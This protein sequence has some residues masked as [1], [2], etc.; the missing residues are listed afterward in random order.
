[1]ALTLT[2]ENFFW[3]K[4]H[5][6]TGVVPV[7]YYMV[8]HLV[9]NSFSLGGPDYFNGVIA[10]FYGMPR[11]I[12]LATEIVLIWIPLLFH[13]LYGFVITSHAKANYFSAKYRWSENRMYLFQRV[14]GLG[15][16]LFLCYHV[17][18]TTINEK[19]TSNEDVVRFAAMRETLTSHGYIF[20]VV[21]ILGVLFASYHLCYGLWNFCIR[22]G[23]TVSERAQTQVQKL[24]GV[25]FVLLTLLGWAALAGFLMP[26]GEFAPNPNGADTMPAVVG[27]L[28]R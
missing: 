8:Q 24:S 13:A 5:S 10:F 7:G 19:L 14:S 1:M 26:H 18:M 15:T 4:L 17:S 25:A 9:L 2:K 28:A 16:F 6:I 3:H 27:T 12:L 20:L 23:I 21:Y 22:W 11:H